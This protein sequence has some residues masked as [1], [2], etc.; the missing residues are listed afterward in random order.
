VK[1]PLKYYE[2]NVSSLVYLLKHTV[3]QD[4]PFIFSSSCTVYGNAD[5][6]PISESSPSIKAV[7]PYGN[8]KQICEDI[9]L[10]TSKAYSNFKSVILRYFNPIGAHS[11]GFI[12]ESPNGIPQNLI[13]FI[14][15]TLIGKREQLLVFGN[16]YSTPD[17]TCVRDYIHVV[18]L[19]DAHIKS[20]E[21]IL[22]NS[23]TKPCDIFNIGTG[24]GSSVLEIINSFERITKNKLNFKI[25]E[26]REGDVSS[27]Y[28]DASKANNVLGWKSKYT[29]DDSLKSAWKWELNSRF[30]RLA[31]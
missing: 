27:S 8:T 10:D 13:P 22:N 1:H 23:S 15:Q 18:D 5:V 31:K 11:S 2:N 26:R 9:I 16:D 25:V 30:N 21:Y 12:G 6:I 4:I 20:L 17:G 7:S 3:N 28:A 29:L 24:K 19:A 14:T